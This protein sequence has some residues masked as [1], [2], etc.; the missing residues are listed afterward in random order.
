MSEQQSNLLTYLLNYLQA[1]ILVH[2]QYTPTIYTC[3]IHTYLDYCGA[4]YEG[5]P[6][7]LSA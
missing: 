7:Y 3:S 4:L 2:V 1:L 5:L 6:P